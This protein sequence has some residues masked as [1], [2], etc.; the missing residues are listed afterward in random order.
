MPDSDY[1]A[2]IDDIDIDARLNSSRARLRILLGLDAV[3]SESD[4]VGQV[5]EPEDRQVELESSIGSAQPQPTSLSHELVDLLL[6][7]WWAGHPARDALHVARAA[8]TQQAKAHPWRLI[9]F[10]AAV[11]AFVVIVRPWRYSVISKSIGAAVLASGTSLLDHSLS[12]TLK[13]VDQ[14]R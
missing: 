14:S 3:K 6:R 11:G 1:P 9:T 10:S 5:R 4:Q 8:L 13:H 12:R 2:N 7:T